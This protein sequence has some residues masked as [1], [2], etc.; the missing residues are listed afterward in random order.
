MWRLHYL[1][2]I[3]T[4]PFGTGFILP[5]V[6]L[7]KTSDVKPWH[8]AA[9]REFPIKNNK[10][11]GHRRGP[12]NRFAG[13]TV[14]PPP[15]HDHDKEKKESSIIGDFKK[16]MDELFRRDGP[17]IEAYATNDSLTPSPMKTPRPN[18]IS[19]VH[20][21]QEFKDVVAAEKERIVVVRWYASYCRSCK[22]IQPYFYRLAEKYREEKVLFVEIPISEKNAV[23]HQG[24]GIPS[25]PFG[26]IYH[27]G[28]GLV[29]ELKISKKMFPRF[30]QILAWYVTGSCDVLDD[31]SWDS[32]SR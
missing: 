13:T 20:S 21:L 12:T 16:R 7:P 22:A 18:Y 2:M 3:L 1:F 24:L 15:I 8:S 4:M 32:L 23:L 10:Q 5:A 6:P 17:L 9:A 26:H 30:A 14:D 25:I 19:V 11:P 27:P 31:G 28:A 29:E